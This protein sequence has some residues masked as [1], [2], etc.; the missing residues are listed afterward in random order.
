MYNLDYAKNA[1]ARAGPKSILVAE[2]YKKDNGD[3]GRRYIIFKDIDKLEDCIEEKE[4]CYNEIITDR[5]NGKIPQIGRLSFD[6]D[7]TEKTFIDNEYKFVHNTFKED[8]ENSI[9]ETFDEYYININTEVFIF[10][11]Q[12]TD[13]RDKKYS[14]HLIVKNAYFV[15]EWAKQSKIFYALLEKIMK[16]NS[17]FDLEGKPIDHSFPKKNTSLRLLGCSKINGNPLL[18]DDDYNIEYSDCIVQ[19]LDMKR[20]KNPIHLTD[21][22]FEKAYL[23]ID[24]KTKHTLEIVSGFREEYDNEEIDD[25]TVEKALDLFKKCKDESLSYRNIVSGYINLTRKSS[26]ACLVNSER[27]H[28]NDGAYIT[29]SKKGKVYFYCRRG[30]GNLFL[31]NINDN[32]DN[33][34]ININKEKE[35]VKPRAK[36][37]ESFKGAKIN[38][39][40]IEAI[41]FKFD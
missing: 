33:N 30:C 41:I 11:W 29:V 32:E 5:N 22:K 10:I 19:V 38:I 4:C 25:E 1:R 8:F 16:N 18:L 39:P 37:C 7:I 12:N 23:S 6:I 21:L 13:H 26:G 36:L 28:D 20:E 9:I 24:D 15:D 2:E 34:N 14:K 3:F 17:H 27:I 40:Q 31:G 35:K